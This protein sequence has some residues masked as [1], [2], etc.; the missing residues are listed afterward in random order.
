MPEGPEPPFRDR[1]AE[2]V[3]STGA[4]SY[5]KLLSKMLRTTA[6][7]ARHF[8]RVPV[9]R[10]QNVRSM[11]D[12]KDTSPSRHCLRVNPDAT[13]SAYS[14]RVSVMES[15]ADGLKRKVPLEMCK[16]PSSGATSFMSPTISVTHWSRG[17][18]E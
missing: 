1:G 17:D 18:K 6:E 13:S 14:C 7:F 12:S 2:S 15:G 5:G 11:R 16:R 3:I 9:G 10:L 8:R 4:W